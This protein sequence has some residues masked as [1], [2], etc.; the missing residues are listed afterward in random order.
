MR[1]ARF[2]A[3][4]LPILREAIEI[5]DSDELK[6]LAPS[7]GIFYLTPAEPEYVALGDRVD[8]DHVMCQLEAFKIFTPPRPSDFNGGDDA[9]YADDVEHEITRI[10]RTNNESVNAGDLLFV[11]RPVAV[12]SAA[13]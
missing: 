3:V 10:N 12:E 11:V 8:L 2:R 6:V 13:A 5:E 1:G 4:V 9:L 7:T